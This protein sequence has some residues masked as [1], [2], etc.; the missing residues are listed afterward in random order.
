MHKGIDHDDARGKLGRGTGSKPGSPY[1]EH[2]LAKTLEQAAIPGDIQ[3]EI[4]VV[5]RDY[6][7][8][9]I[10]G[11]KVYHPGLRRSITHGLPA[12]IRLRSES[13]YIDVDNARVRIDERQDF[14][15]IADSDE[16]AVFNCDCARGR[17]RPIQ[18]HESA[19]AQNEIGNVER[20]G[21]ERMS[22][23]RSDMA[24]DCLDADRPGN[25]PKM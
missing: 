6:K 1:D 8:V 2:M 12:T 11:V 22:P 3:P 19:V 9:A 24:L 15:L 25:M 7:G 17:L 16:R 18:C 20:G 13:C 5:N 4:A 21:H 14:R 23:M 10:D